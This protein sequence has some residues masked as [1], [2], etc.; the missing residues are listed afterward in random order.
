M[1][2]LFKLPQLKHLIKLN[3]C[4]FS[5]YRHKTI[6]EILEL[7]NKKTDISKKE[8]DIEKFNLYFTIL[9]NNKA[10]SLGIIS[11]ILCWKQYFLLS[12]GFGFVSLFK[13]LQQNSNF[14]RLLKY[15][16]D[17]FTDTKKPDINNAV[18]EIC[19]YI[20]NHP[21]LKLF[22]NNENSFTLLTTW[23]LKDKF[24]L[25]NHYRT[26]YT[27][28]DK[29]YTINTHIVLENRDDECLFVWATVLFFTP[30]HFRIEYLRVKREGVYPE[31]NYLIV[32]GR[33]QGIEMEVEDLKNVNKRVFTKYREGDKVDYNI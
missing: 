27:L 21:D 6:A 17:T 11:I 9:N 10:L 4:N 32:D 14:T 25:G 23:G 8:E 15:S 7:K 2:K 12:F 22:Y 30:T 3:K 16:E 1:N 20:Y 19:K 13:L 33:R 29:R 5:D 26:D 18:E 31:K 24:G 28:H